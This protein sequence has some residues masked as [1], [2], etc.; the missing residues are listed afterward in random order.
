[1]DPASRLIS[2]PRSPVSSCSACLRTLWSAACWAS[3]AVLVG[4]W[5]T[6]HAPWRDREW[7][8]ALSIV[9]PAGQL[10]QNTS[11][12][13]G[14]RRAA[15]RASRGATV[16]PCL[17]RP[18]G[19]C[20]C[21]PPPSGSG[22]HGLSEGPPPRLPPQPWLLWP[23]ACAHPHLIL[24]GG[25]S[26]LGPRRGLPPQGRLSLRVSCS[27]ESGKRPP[28][29]AGSSQWRGG[30]RA[31]GWFLQPGRCRLQAGQLPEQGGPHRPTGG[32]LLL[33]LCGMPAV[34]LGAQGGLP[35]GLDGAFVGGFHAEA[36]PAGCLALRRAGGP[37]PYQPEW[38]LA[39]PEEAF[40]QGGCLPL[41]RMLLLLC[42]FSCRR[43]PAPIRAGGWVSLPGPPS[44]HGAS[45][46][47]GWG[48][49]LALPISSRAA[50]GPV[51][52]QIASPRLAS[53][54]PPL[55]PGFL[56][57]PGYVAL[58]PSGPSSAPLP[59]S[60]RR[61][62][63]EGLPTGSSPPARCVTIC[64]ASPRSFCR[65]PRSGWRAFV[66][67]PG[68][69]SCRRHTRT[70]RQKQAGQ[71]PSVLPNG[72]KG[73]QRYRSGLGVRVFYVVG[74]GWVATVHLWIP[75]HLSSARFPHSQISWEHLASPR[76][77]WSLLSIGT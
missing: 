21:R 22:G 25:R 33:L 52:S 53:P 34:G 58:N 20:R 30:P 61:N 29:G 7:C 74:A 75:P 28:A 46:N 59:F 6:S 68:Q 3:A 39:L 71:E 73:P 8:P 9:R 63:V 5:S 43:N 24:R 31:P 62:L 70:H 45:K 10:P 44:L 4:S 64:T 32:L 14:G 56:R 12:P 55:A 23:G 38:A 41:G 42:C 50:V 1:M 40:P 26:S 16:S 49:P 19:P 36:A 15:A 37:F 69:A 57:L 76:G 47:M 66:T 17:R 60:F 51:P 35:D 27:A 11:R 48:Q 2:R 77:K 54:G 67:F 72:N 13:A 65:V 18:L